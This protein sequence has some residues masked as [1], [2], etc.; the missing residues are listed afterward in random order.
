MWVKICS[1]A[2]KVKMTGIFWLN[3]GEEIQNTFTMK[4]TLSSTMGRMKRHVI[5]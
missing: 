4:K 1:I 2:N 3:F 5:R